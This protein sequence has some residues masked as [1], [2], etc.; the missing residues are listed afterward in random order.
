MF[1][2]GRARS[3]GNSRVG[4]HSN[5][6][7]SGLDQEPHHHVEAADEWCRSKGIAIRFVGITRR[8]LQHI[9]SGFDHSSSTN[10]LKNV[11]VFNRSREPAALSP[12][13]LSVNI[14]VVKKV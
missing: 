11:Q 4:Q 13:F 9:Q 12:F 8:P 1:S 2:S 14:S 6:D 7:P 3:I 10:T 5:F